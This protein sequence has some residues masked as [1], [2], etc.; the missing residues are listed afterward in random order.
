MPVIPDRDIDCGEIYE[1]A[2]RE[3]IGLLQSSPAA[4][5]AAMVPATPAWSVHDVLSHL[6]GIAADLNAQ[7]FDD[8]SDRWTAAQVESRANHSLSELAAEWDREAPLFED[9]LRVFGYDLG[10]HFVGDLLQHVGDVRHA[11]GLVHPADDETLAVA[12]DS[13]FVTFE[14]SLE[15]AA[16]GSVEISDGR[17]R[18]ALG[19]GPV[20]ASVTAD[21]Y[22]LFR[23]LGG[24]RS[25]A[26]VRALT[27]SGD[28][29]AVMPAVSA[30]P[31]PEAP[32]VELG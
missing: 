1:Q 16:T 30:Y 2:R 23:S 11:L 17:D 10:S 8:D 32:I 26:Q 3:L 4:D 24:R 20:V 5:L 6:V 12:L 18:W 28:L 13:Y 15:A 25:A 14:K 19:S 31:M 7:A 9:G 29:D 21:R 27:W 22:E